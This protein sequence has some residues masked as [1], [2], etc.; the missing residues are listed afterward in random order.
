VLGSESKL[1]ERPNG[2][3]VQLMLYVAYEVIPSRESD[4]T[5]SAYNLG[6]AVL[7]TGIIRELRLL[8]S[9][10]AKAQQT[11]TTTTSAAP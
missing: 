11:L 8:L 9:A 2:T 5:V 10:T 4:F 7:R 3:Y 6:S 1:H